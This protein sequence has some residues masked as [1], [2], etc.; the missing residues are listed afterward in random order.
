MITPELVFDMEGPQKLRATRH[1]IK[2]IEKTIRQEMRV[3]YIHNRKVECIKDI[4]ARDL[5]KEESF[6][7][8]KK[9]L[10]QHKSQ[11]KRF[12]K[13]GKIKWRC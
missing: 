5:A 7:E 4:T 12:I 1:L 8:F 13:T 9:I 2:S 3:I 6:K 10:R 11:M